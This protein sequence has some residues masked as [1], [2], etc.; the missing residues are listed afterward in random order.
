[1][2]QRQTDRSA[3]RARALISEAM[4]AANGE[5]VARLIAFPGENGRPRL[6]VLSSSDTEDPV[7]EATIIR[8]ADVVTR[9]RRRLRPMG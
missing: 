6:R 1:M 7:L 2:S 3:A 5:E 8:L 9:Q 4:L